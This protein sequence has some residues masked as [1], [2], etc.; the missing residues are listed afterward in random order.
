M[1]KILKYVCPYCSDELDTHN[2][3]KSH[4]IAE[5]QAEEA[6]SP[7]KEPE[8]AFIKGLSTC[9]F[10]H[11]MV[12]ITRKEANQI[13]KRLMETYLSGIKHPPRGRILTECY[14]ILT[15]RPDDELRRTY[16]EAIRELRGLGIRFK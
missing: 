13:I 16:D 12:G 8:K 6:A 9:S 7:A 2:D 1:D 14:D 3:L 5:H 4:I 10:G 15:M 11:G